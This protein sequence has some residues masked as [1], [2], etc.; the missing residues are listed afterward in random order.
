MHAADQEAKPGRRERR[1]AAARR[2][3]VDHARQL[4]IENGYNAT[5]VE[6]IAQAADVAPRTLFRYFPTKASILFAE[7]D[8]LRE[9]M[10]ERLESSPKDQPPL[11]ALGEVMRWFIDEVQANQEELVWGFRL[12]VKQDVDGTSDRHIGKEA[13][14]HRIAAFLADRLEVDIDDDPRPLTW[15]SSAMAVMVMSLRRTTRD[16]QQGTDAVELFDQMLA[17][18][19][20]ALAVLAKRRS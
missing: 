8:E 1:I 4:F 7:F 2:T 5:T 11:D 17:S 16:P 14:N 20:E 10:L 9:E 18:T 13:T 12:C 19:S 15:A 6:E 3:I